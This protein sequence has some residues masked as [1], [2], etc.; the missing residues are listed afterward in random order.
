MRTG[1]AEDLLAEASWLEGLARA[2][3]GDR[4]EARDLVQEV[5]LRTL[6]ERP[7]G[8][9]RPRAW[10]AQVLRNTLGMRRRARGARGARERAAARPEATVGGGEVVARAESLRLLVEAVLALE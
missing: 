7:E 8:V 10:L 1:R 4:E 2:L 5:W 9:Q 3:V 6:E